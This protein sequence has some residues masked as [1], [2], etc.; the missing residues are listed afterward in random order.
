MPWEWNIF[1]QFGTYAKEQ[2]ITNNIMSF[3]RL[4]N[5]YLIHTTCFDLKGLSSGVT[6][7]WY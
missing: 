4:R 1:V 5:I 7:T 2:M 6:N 3:Y